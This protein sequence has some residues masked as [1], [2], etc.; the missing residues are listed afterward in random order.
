MIPLFEQYVVTT[1]SPREF[2]KRFTD[3][4]RLDVMKWCN[5]NLQYINQGRD[6]R[7][8]DLGGNFVVKVAKNENGYAQNVA[9][10]GLDVYGDAF[11]KIE[12]IGTDWQWVVYPKAEKITRKEFEQLSGI[13]FSQF[14][15]MIQ[16][17]H[18][19]HI[20]HKEVDIGFMD[21]YELIQDIDNVVGDTSA[22][23]CTDL[24][25]ITNWGRIGNRLVL[26]DM[27]TFGQMGQ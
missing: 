7:V 2:E 8:F 10:Q 23:Y 19:Y 5:Q 9:G 17:I 14:K 11:L 1:L 15:D 24:A 26:V 27:G 6:R 20:W 13:K 3:S 12:Q 16:K 4:S 25:R 18:D 22:E 21:D